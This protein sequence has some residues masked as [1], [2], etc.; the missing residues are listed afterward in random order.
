MV[1]F[2]RSQNTAFDS[3][4]G[5]YIRILN[6]A[7]IPSKVIMWSRE[8]SSDGMHKGSDCSY[9]REA[10]IGGGARNG[11]SILGWNIHL[12][13]ALYRL[14]GE[15]STIHAV[16]LDSVLPAVLMKL[17]FSKKLIFDVYD[18]YSDSRNI[19][20]PWCLLLDALEKFASKTSDFVLLPDA[21]RIKQLGIDSKNVKILENIP[22]IPGAQAPKG[23]FQLKGLRWD[24]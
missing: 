7:K 11:L 20:F 22:P 6:G 12:L 24:T 13:R 4:L 18:K 5:K 8:S 17:V 16:D 9:S 1:I 21:S 2:L 23:I 14:R 3:R 10:K 15:Y 19:G